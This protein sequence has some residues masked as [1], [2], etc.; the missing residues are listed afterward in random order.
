MLANRGASGIDGLVS[1]ALGVASA[2]IGPTFA[3]IGDLS[4]LYDVGAL[5]W[6]GARLPADLVLVV[7]NNRGGA[8]FGALDQRTLPERRPASR[9][10]ADM[11]VSG[12]SAPPPAWDMT[13]WSGC[14]SST[15]P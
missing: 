2:G 6:N 9:D 11:L 12:R 8:I 4:F 14:P 7:A 13:G 10:A 1:T 15:E 3:L 5:L